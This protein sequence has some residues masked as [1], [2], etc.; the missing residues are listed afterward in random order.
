MFLICALLPAYQIRFQFFGLPT[1]FLEIM[2]LLLFISWFINRLKIKDLRLKIEGLKDWGWLILAWLI[3]GLVAVI[4]SPDK[5]GALGHWRAYFL[6]P[7][8]LLII[9]LGLSKSDSNT[10]ISTNETNASSE[11]TKSLQNCKDNIQNYS[12]IYTNRGNSFLE[13]ILN[14]LGISALYCSLWAISQKWLGGG[15][16]S[17]E[18][19]GAA[20]VWR[21]TGPFPQP[22]FLGLY[23]TPIIILIIGQFFSYIF[24]LKS[25]A[26]YHDRDKKKR[27][28]KFLKEIFQIYFYCLIIILSIIA[29]ILARSEGAILGLF[30]GLIFSG[31]IYR[32]SRKLVLIGLIILIIIIFSLPTTRNYLITK[33]TFQD[34]SGQLRL[35]IWQGTIKLLKDHPIFGAGLRGYQ[36]LIPQYQKPY[37]S[38]KTKELISVEIHPYPH[39]LFLAI[40]S[41]LGI[42]GLIVFLWILIKFFYQG[43]KNATLNT[44]I[45]PN[46]SNKIF[47]FSF[48]IFNLSAMV[49]LLTHG[50]FDTPYFKNDLAILFWLIVGLMIVQNKNNY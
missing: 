44:R 34:L 27:V 15:V 32:K 10:Q 40:W 17:T 4:V 21:A 11:T 31:L 20:K 49:A 9:F 28:V 42:L 30:V 47:S 36:K 43:F 25:S 2:I 45:H 19:W 8:F 46:D 3:V 24:D 7:I 37:Y 39:N 6:E 38:P 29:I 1:T 14:A 13:L 18:I 26:K 23:L 12:T 22:N 41:E 35:N 48:L 50:A 33:F 16:M 5:W